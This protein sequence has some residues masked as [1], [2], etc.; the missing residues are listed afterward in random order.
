MENLVSLLKRNAAKYPQDL[1]VYWPKGD[2]YF[3]WQEIEQRSDKLAA[4]FIEKD[5]QPGEK[6]GLYLNNTPDFVIGFFAILKAGGIVVPINPKLTAAEVNYIISDSL[7]SG[8]IYADFLKE[9]VE[10]INKNNFKFYLSTGELQEIY[11][12]QNLVLGK[13]V[14]RNFDDIAE[15]LYTSG[16]TGKPKGVLLSHRAIYFAGMMYIYE[17]N[18]YYRDKVLIL[19]PLTH[20]AP[21]NLT[22]IG[23]VMAG[24][25]L[26]LGDYHPQDF[27]EIAQKEKIHHF[28]GAP[29]A[30]LLPLQLP[31]FKN[32]E[33]PEAKS[34]SYGGA[35]LSKDKVEVIMK[36]YPGK[37]VCVYGLTE[38]GPNGTS[39]KYE[40]HFFH[41]GSIGCRGTVNMEVKIVNTETGKECMPNEPGE[42]I[43]RG[44]TLMEGYLNNPEATAETLKDGWLYTGDIAYR[45]EEGYIYILDRKK[46]MIITGGVNVYPKE[47]EDVLLSMPEI[48]DVAVFGLPHPEWG[49]TV[50]ATVV[51]KPGATLTEERIIEY[52]AKRLAKY[53]QP[54]VIFFADTIPR[55]PSGKILKKVLKETYKL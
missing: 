22:M 7:A 40:E 23:G 47:V 43:L 33:L 19:M 5:F 8:I 13:T 52:A 14:K 16:T 18:I 6:V 21:L 50:C 12:S 34:W 27:L 20:S 10:E 39:L 1:G 11:K 29:V 53:K 3:T 9:N 54:K 55:N 30:Y 15:I 41:A 26:V 45:D 37:V 38:A 17:M 25:E 42:I 44:P 35:P 51:L 31:S 4:Y 48:A 24:A 32:Y 36:N 49:E 46:D 2:L 28:F